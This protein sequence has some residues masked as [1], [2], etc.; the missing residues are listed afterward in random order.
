M[1]V[2]LA[3]SQGR[4]MGKSNPTSKVP[5][6]PMALK[7][8]K[9]SFERPA[10]MQDMISY[11]PVPRRTAHA[12]QHFRGSLLQS[13]LATTA[14]NSSDLTLFDI[15]SIVLDWIDRLN[16]HASVSLQKAGGR[17]LPLQESV[18]WAGNPASGRIP[19][20]RIPAPPRV[21]I[22]KGRGQIRPY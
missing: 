4:P 10:D 11:W 22:T 8:S 16:K 18:I 9:R 14:G 12:T 15:P 1:A 21:A 7:R 19:I 13:A 17:R 6:C 2:F 20:R 5:P 3:Y